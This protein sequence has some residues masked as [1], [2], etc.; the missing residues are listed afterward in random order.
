MKTKIT[1]ESINY[2]GL[3][4]TG[5]RDYNATALYRKYGKLYLVYVWVDFYHAKIRISKTQINGGKALKGTS[6][7]LNK[8]ALET[9]LIIK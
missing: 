3:P 8:Y 4:E 1:V 2:Y 5:Y 9:R 6:D 7:A